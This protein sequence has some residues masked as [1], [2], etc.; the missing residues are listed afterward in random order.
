MFGYKVAYPPLCTRLAVCAV[1][2]AQLAP[3]DSTILKSCPPASPDPC[4]FQAW[5]LAIWQTLMD[6][7]VMLNSQAVVGRARLTAQIAIK[8]ALRPG[9]RVA[10]V[11]ME[12]SCSWRLNSY[13]SPPVTLPSVP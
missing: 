13:L 9:A 1:H 8:A 12:S 6:Y 7:T 10:T 5:A 4:P 11:V 2:W 3:S